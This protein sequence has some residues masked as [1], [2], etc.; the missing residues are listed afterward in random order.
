M[1]S[2]PSRIM[3]VRSRRILVPEA[4]EAEIGVKLRVEDSDDA[5]DDDA[6]CSR[7]LL[8]PALAESSRD[9]SVSLDADDRALIRRRIFP[10]LSRVHKPRQVL[11]QPKRITAPTLHELTIN[12]D[13]F[14]RRVARV[15]TLNTR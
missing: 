1:R 9:R 14:E 15:R 7:K 13:V 2:A 12:A 4:A 3:P 11:D 8:P 6:D 5:G 10:P